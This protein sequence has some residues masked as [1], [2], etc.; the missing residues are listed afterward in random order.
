M[1]TKK[2][3]LSLLVV[4]LLALSLVTACPAPTTTEEVEQLNATIADLEAQLAAANATIVD[5]EAQLAA[6]MGEPA[7]EIAYGGRLDV[8]FTA[9]E[10][11]ETL[12]CDSNW[13]YTEMGCVFWPLVY[14]QLWIMGP[15]PDYEVLPMLATSWETED[16]IT[17]T[18][19]LREDAVFHDGVPVTAE[20]VAFTI[21]NLPNADPAWA[22][23]DIITEPGS[24]KVIDDYTV[25]FTLEQSIGTRWPAAYWAP[26][27][28]K[29]IWEPYTDDMLSFSNDEAIGSGPY[30]LKE[31]KAAQYV[32]FEAN[33]DYWGGRPYLD[34]VVFRTYG[35]EDAQYMALKSGEADMIGYLGCSAVAAEDFIGLED[36]EVIVSPGIGLQWLSFNLYKDTPLQDLEVRKAIMY[37]IDR[38]RVI[39]MAFLGYAQTADSFIYPE[40]AEHNPN[41]PQYAYDVDLANEILDNAGYLDSDGDGMRDDLTFELLAPSDWT[42]ELKAATLIKEQLA[43]IGIDISL[44]VL[45]LDTY[46]EYIY[47]PEEE[48]YEIAIATEE[49]GPHGEWMWEF[50]RSYEAGGEGW[51]TAYWANPDFDEALDAMLAEVDVEQRTAYLYEMQ[52]LMA[53]D[54]PYGVLYRPDLINPVRTDE[55]EGYV[56]TMGGISTWI[57]PWT[58]FELHLK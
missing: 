38:D 1:R 12:L 29:H 51:N 49:P 13:Q 40:V 53:E 23:T 27:L 4:A 5:L 34:E 43:E 24:V 20:D 15:A 56:E 36:M 7:E 17:W 55:F 19:Y 45:D 14:D 8:G 31:F 11:L 54:L 42:D 30:K 39:E 47:T 32:W 22:F 9:G 50:C 16:G 6:A 57:N 37:G 44:T 25:E 48:E 33:E 26:I 10:G 2:G 28:P 41:L 58:Y 3:L 46:Y 18:F 35:S 52:M 21:E